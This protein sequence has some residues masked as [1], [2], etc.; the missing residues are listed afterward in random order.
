MGLASIKC[1]TRSRLGSF[2]FRQEYPLWLYNLSP[3]RM[4][5]PS[6]PPRAAIKPGEM[7]SRP[8]CVLAI[9]AA[10]FSAAAALRQDASTEPPQPILFQKRTTLLC[11]ELGCLATTSTAGAA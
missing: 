1:G 11:L 3:D 2:V 8:Q 5:T 4:V 9:G 10:F 7:G 6:G